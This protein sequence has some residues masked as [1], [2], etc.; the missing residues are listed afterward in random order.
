MFERR[1]LHARIKLAGS[2]LSRDHRDHLASQ[3]RR[4]VEGRCGEH[5]YVRSGT[6]LV[7]TGQGVIEH[8]PKS[9]SAPARRA[10]PIGGMDAA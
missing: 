5:G 6:S 1:R 4:A 2:Q 10:G 8:A 9:S 7:E 3:L